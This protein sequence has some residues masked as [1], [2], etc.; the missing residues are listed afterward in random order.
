M[1]LLGSI[2]TLDEQHDAELNTMLTTVEFLE[3][4]FYIARCVY[5]SVFIFSNFSVM[6]SV[7][8]NICC[9]IGIYS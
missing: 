7:Q 5:V 9:T 2:I 3:F 6:L 8:E 1:G 4:I